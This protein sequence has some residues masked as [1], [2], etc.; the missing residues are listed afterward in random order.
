MV[1][2]IALGNDLSVH[3]GMLFSGGSWLDEYD[4][5]RWGI[6][7]CTFALVPSVPDSSSGLR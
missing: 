6:T 1:C 5:V 7:T 2:S 3:I 4:S